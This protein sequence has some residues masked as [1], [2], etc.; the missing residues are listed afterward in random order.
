MSLVKRLLTEQHTSR[1][2]ILY[3]YMYTHTRVFFYFKYIF[4][5]IVLFIFNMLDGLELLRNTLFPVV[6]SALTFLVV[7]AS[8]CMVFTTSASFPLRSQK[9]YWCLFF[10]FLLSG[11]CIVLR[12]CKS[13]FDMS[14]NGRCWYLDSRLAR[15][16]ADITLFSWETRVVD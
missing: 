9:T 16:D 14:F 7:S 5:F 4:I 6:L 1:E 12:Y 8:C 13:Y 3:I 2:K 11:V 10:T 15:Y